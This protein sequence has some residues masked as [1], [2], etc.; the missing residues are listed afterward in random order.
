MIE[1]LLKSWT[2]VPLIV[3]WDFPLIVDSV[4][5]LAPSTRGTD[6]AAHP[7]SVLSQQILGHVL[8]DLQP[9]APE[10][11]VLHAIGSPAWLVGG[12]FGDPLGDL[13]GLR[14]I[15]RTALPIQRSVQTALG[16]APEPDVE[17]ARDDAGGLGRQFDR[18]AV[19]DIGECKQPHAAMREAVDGGSGTQ[20]VPGFGQVLDPGT[21]PAPI[22]TGLLVRPYRQQQIEEL[23]SRFVIEIAPAFDLPSWTRGLQDRNG[24]P[25]SASSSTMASTSSARAATARSSFR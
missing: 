3:E 22:I 18:H 6:A 21:P 19:T 15:K 2:R 24:E 7:R 10:D 13:D 14:L 4:M 11:F 20:F 5:R 17:G 12:G 25:S 9:V 8:A 16:S 23:L 1:R